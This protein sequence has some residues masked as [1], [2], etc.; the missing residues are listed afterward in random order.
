M[1]IIYKGEEYASVNDARVAA[2]L[3]T[4]GHVHE[5]IEDLQGGYAHTCWRIIE[6]GENMI[7]ETRLACRLTAI[8]AARELE[9][10]RKYRRQELENLAMNMQASV[11]RLADLEQ[12]WKELQEII[13]G[14]PECF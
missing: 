8:E 12:E 10:N 2:N 13:E 14:L 4:Q 3:P 6:D 1:I 11:Q 5:I 9:E 7:G